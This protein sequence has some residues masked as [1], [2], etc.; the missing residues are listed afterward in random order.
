M[1]NAVNAVNRIGA[2]LASHRG[3]RPI[4]S[5]KVL[6]GTHRPAFHSAHVRAR[7]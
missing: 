4:S 7:G 6:L 5:L 2:L 3:E 1:R